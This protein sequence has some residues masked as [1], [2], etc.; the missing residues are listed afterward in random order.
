MRN[1][2]LHVS[3]LSEVNIFI[4]FTIALACLDEK[5]LLCNNESNKKSWVGKKIQTFL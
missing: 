2:H 3:I 5:K 4:M 1:S